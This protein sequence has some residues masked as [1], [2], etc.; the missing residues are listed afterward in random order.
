MENM[1]ISSLKEEL[2]SIHSSTDGL[3]EI[4]KDSKI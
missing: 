4:E 2:Y 3:A 1:D